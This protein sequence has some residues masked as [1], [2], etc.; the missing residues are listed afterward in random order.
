MR[1]LHVMV[2]LA[3]TYTFPELFYPLTFFSMFIT[4]SMLEAIPKSV[5]SRL[6]TYYLIL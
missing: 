5:P 6:S 1:N 4:Y 3:A 2:L